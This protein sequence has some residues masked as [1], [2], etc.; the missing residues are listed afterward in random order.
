MDAGLH[1]DRTPTHDYEPTRK[2]AMAA[3]STL[4]AQDSKM[5]QIIRMKP[6]RRGFFGTR[7][8]VLLA[9][10]G[11]LI[12]ALLASYWDQFPAKNVKSAAT[13]EPDQIQVIDGDTIRANGQ[14]YRLVGYHAPESGLEAKCES[15]RTLAARAT[16]RLRQIVT[17]GELRFER[18]PCACPSGTEG[19]QRCNYGRLCAVITSAGRDVGALMIAEG[20]ARQYVCSNTRCPLRQ[21]WC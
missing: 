3:S 12:V 19:T 11:I 5:A 16:S 7:S 13:I 20:L 18:V 9:G 17:A 4:L 6:R 14:V 1:K 2:G 21:G 10:F 15:E 8:L